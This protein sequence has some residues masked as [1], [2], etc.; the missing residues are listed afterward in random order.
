MS[1]NRKVRLGGHKVGQ[2]LIS[3]LA[4]PFTLSRLV[5]PIYLSCIGLELG[6]TTNKKH[7][8]NNSL[9]PLTCP[10]MALMV[11]LILTLL[12]AKVTPKGDIDQGVWGKLD[13]QSHWEMTQRETSI[14]VDR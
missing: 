13:I 1:K 11:K 7:R 2:K 4:S 14:K 5:Y 8:R 12:H 3:I 10:P 9:C 6:L